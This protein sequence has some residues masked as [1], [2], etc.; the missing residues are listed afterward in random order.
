MSQKKRLLPDAFW[1]T[2]KPDFDN[3]AKIV[4]DALNK[5]AWLDDAQIAAAWVR[6]VYSD[7][8]GLNVKF[9]V[10]A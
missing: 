7:M 4:G 5:V 2:S 6:K 9:E 1:R 10:L 3:L 8:P